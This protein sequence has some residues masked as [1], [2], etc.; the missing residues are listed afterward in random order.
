VKNDIVGADKKLGI[1]LNENNLNYGK[2]SNLKK[3]GN[4]MK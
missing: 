3:I 4:E 2:G 1:G